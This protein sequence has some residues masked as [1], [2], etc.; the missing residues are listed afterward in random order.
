MKSKNVFWH[1]GKI[2]KSDRENLLGQKGQVIW[3]TGLSGSGKSTISVE[4]EKK[5][6]SKDKLVY[7]LDGDN[8]RQ[9]IN[10][11]L[12]FSEV[13]RKENIRR[14]AHIAKLMMDVGIIV[15]CSFI[16]PKESLRQEVKKVIGSDNIE[17][18]YVKSS[19]ETCRKR[20]PKGLYRKADNNEISD[21]TGIS[22]PFEEPENSDLVLDTEIQSI[23]QCVES[24]L[25]VIKM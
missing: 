1:H 21:F 4:V 11:D 13:D 16:T 5:L 25:Q 7:R 17:L 23:N 14:I 10:S 6:F 2:G 22:A 15:L 9:G 12:G 3:F 19:I 20:D 8:I 18:I 24:V